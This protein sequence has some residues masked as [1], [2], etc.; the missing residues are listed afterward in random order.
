MK[1]KLLL[2]LILIGTFLHSA[3][4][5]EYSLGLHLMAGIPQNEFSEVTDAVGFGGNGNFMFYP[6]KNFPL[7]IGGQ[8]GYMIYGNNRQNEDLIAQIKL[9]NTVI[10]E[11][12][13][14]LEIVTT[15][16]I[17]NF[18]GVMRLRAPIKLVQPYVE[19]IAGFNYMSTH[20]KILDKS[21][22]FRFSSPDNNV[23]VSKTQLEDFILLYGFGGGLMFS[24]NKN[25][26]I[27]LR[28]DYTIGGEGEY[29][30]ASDTK[31]WNVEFISADQ[32]DPDEL[33]GDDL[34]ISALPKKSKTDM[35]FISGGL[36]FMF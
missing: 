12:Y 25:M 13:M 4:A 14:P 31:Q 3:K 2:S 10:D 16:S 24:I 9:G 17:V 35:L 7:G 11:I 5:Q 19:G 21:D 32:Y 1:T 33:S 20:T 30:D 22:D 15:N 18:M 27:D 36:T 34:D 26:W 28:V 8:L 23:I 6:G 29:F